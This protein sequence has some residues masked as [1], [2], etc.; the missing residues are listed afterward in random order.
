MWII[1]TVSVVPLCRPESMPCVWSHVALIASWSSCVPIKAQVNWLILF[2]IRTLL[3]P[4][5]AILRT[6]SIYPELLTIWKNMT[7]WILALTNWSFVLKDC[8]IQWSL[9]WH[10]YVWNFPLKVFVRKKLYSHIGST[11]SKNWNSWV[12]YGHHL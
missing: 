8:M 9:N 12:A 3:Q 1:I 11:G 10:F 4:R 2:W 5:Q 7:P 6:L